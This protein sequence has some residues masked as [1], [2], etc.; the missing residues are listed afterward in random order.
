MRILSSIFLLVF[1][2]ISHLQAETLSVRALHQLIE[3]NQRFMQ[4]KTI[5]P[6]CTAQRREETILKQKPFAIILGC[7]DSRVSPEILFDQGL[8][9][10]FIVRVAGNVVGPIELASIEY[11]AIH[12]HSVLIVVLGHESCGA[13]TAT[14]EGKTEDIEAIASL[15]QPAMIKTAKEPGDRLENTIKE[16]VALSV[17]QLQNNSALK[18]LVEKQ[19]LVIKGG[20]YNFHTGYV[21]FQ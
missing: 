1:L 13:V 17:N 10:L 9:D 19:E 11:A 4:G 12:L 14:L 8:G 16:N 2:A 21:E 15:I 18:R 3:G 20:Y 7:S 5:H 6:H